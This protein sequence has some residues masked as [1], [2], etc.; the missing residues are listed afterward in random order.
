ME[1][2]VTLTLER[3]DNQIFVF[4]E[5][6]YGFYLNHSDVEVIVQSIIP[7]CQ[8]LFYQNNNVC[9]EPVISFDITELMSEGKTTLCFQTVD[10]LQIPDLPIPGTWMADGEYKHF[11]V[12][13]GNDGGVHTRT[14]KRI[15]SDLQTHQ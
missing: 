9:V 12:P 3:S 10:R 14:L 5:D 15:M 7:L 4:S 1:Y 6:L 2:S 8:H 13:T 11:Y